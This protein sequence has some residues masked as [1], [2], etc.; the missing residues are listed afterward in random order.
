MQQGGELSCF[1]FFAVG[2]VTTVVLVAVFA[3]VF[4]GEKLPLLGWLG[5]SLIAAGA[6]LVA[7]A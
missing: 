5:V 6:A 7:L 3:A 1:L 2:L 4:L